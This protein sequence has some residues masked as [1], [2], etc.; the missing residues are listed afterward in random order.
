[1]TDNTPKSAQNP[2]KGKIAEIPRERIQIP[3]DRLRGLKK[4]RVEVLKQDISFN[5]QLQPILVQENDL[6]FMLVD[7]QHRLEALRILNFV[8]VDAIVL[9]KDMPHEEVRYSGLMANINREDLTKLERAEHIAGIDAAWKA[10]NPGARHGGDRRSKRLRVVKDREAAEEGKGAIL[11]LSAEVAELTGLSHRT[12]KECLQ[13]SRHLLCNEKI[14]RRLAPF[15]NQHKFLLKLS[16]QPADQQEPILDL[17]L[18]E[19]SPAKSIEDAVSILNDGALPSKE[20]KYFSNAVSN[21]GRM[22]S[23]ERSVFVTNHKDEI[24]AIV[25]KE[26]WI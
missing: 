20:D 21:W 23:R 6:G 8:M 17:I 11:N 9:P 14:K 7:G 25:R 26:G 12:F 19:E 16:Q 3:A 15:E 2:H 18:D 22:S 5:Q 13:I 10:M 24:L 1:M 4:H